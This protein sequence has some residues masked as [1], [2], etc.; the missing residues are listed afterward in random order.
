MLFLRTVQ[1]KILM[2]DFEFSSE[3][4]FEAKQGNLCN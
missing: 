1:Q 2:S 3:F 4:F